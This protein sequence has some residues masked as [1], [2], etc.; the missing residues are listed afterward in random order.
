MAAKWI[1]TLVGSLD[2]KKQYKRHMARMG[3][4]YRHQSDAATSPSWR[5]SIRHERG[6]GSPGRP[7]AP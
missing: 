6:K 5:R 1:E 7:L 3:W 4:R 2:Q